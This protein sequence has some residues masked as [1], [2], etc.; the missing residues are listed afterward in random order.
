M[1]HI[2]IKNSS[3]AEMFKNKIS[4]GCL[5][6]VTANFFKMNLFRIAYVTW[7]MTNPFFAAVLIL[8]ITD[9]R[10]S[11]PYQLQGYCRLLQ[12]CDRVPG[13]VSDGFY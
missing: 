10:N 11:F 3:C 8:F 9:P 4:S 13:C 1:I 7:F 2:E 6:T 5:T 12:M